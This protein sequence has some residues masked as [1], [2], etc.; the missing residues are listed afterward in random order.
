MKVFINLKLQATY[1]IVLFYFAVIHLNSYR[2]WSHSINQ[3]TSYLSIEKQ[4]CTTDYWQIFWKVKMYFA[5]AVIDIISK[6][7]N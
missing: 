4:N 2:V 5:A 7:L 1:H 3:F 6:N